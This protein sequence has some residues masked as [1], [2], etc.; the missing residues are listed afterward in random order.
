[1][2]VLDV[3]NENLTQI[4]NSWAIPPM[5]SDQEGNATLNRQ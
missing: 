1:M 4:S 5:E 2:F 3:G